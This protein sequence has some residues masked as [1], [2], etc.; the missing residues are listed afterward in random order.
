LKAARFVPT[1]VIVTGGLCSAGLATW[2][3]A[4]SPLTGDERSAVVSRAADEIDRGYVFVDIGKKMAEHLRKR[5]ADGAYNTIAEPQAFADT[6]TRDLRSV[7]DDGHLRTSY[8]VRRRAV[9][10]DHLARA[11]RPSST[12]SDSPAA[13]AI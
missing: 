3:T 7:S 9:E 6:L 1:F 4:S 5:L 13:L 10:G 12:R 8:A 11:P 2:Q